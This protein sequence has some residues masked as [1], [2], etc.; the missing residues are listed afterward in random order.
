[1]NIEKD[2]MRQKGLALIFLTLLIALSVTT[3]LFMLLDS[4][5]VKNEQNKQ[6]A[7]ILSKAKTAL[8]G[9]AI[10][11]ISSGQRPGDLIRPDSLSELPANY[12]GSAEGGCLDASKANGLPLVTSDANMRCLGRLPWKDLG[13]SVSGSSE[14]D[15]TGIMPWYAVSG[16]LVD[17][18]CLTILNSNTLNLVNNPSPAPLDCSGLTLP[19]PWLTIR[20]AKGNIISNRV[21]AV[22]FLPS[23]ARGAQTR[24]SSPNLG[25]ANQYLDSV[26]V[27]SSCAVPCVPGTYNNADMDNDFIL[28]PESSHLAAENNFNDQLVYITIEDLIAAVA[29]RAAGEARSV[30]NHYNTENTHFPYAAPLGSTVNNFKSAGTNLTG[31]LPVDGTDKCSCSSG[32]SCS[33]SYNLLVNVSHNRTTGGAY[34]VATGS[35]ARSSR[36]CSCTGAGL[37]ENA[38]STISF[39]C[40]IAGNCNFVGSGDD[41]QFSYSPKASFAKIIST[42]GACSIV[43]GKAVCD[44]VGDFWLGLNV[45]LWFT[46]NIWQDFFYYQRDDAVNQL[47]VGSVTNVNAMLIATGAPILSIPQVRPSVNLNDYLDSAQNTNGDLTYESTNKPRDS[48][49]NDQTFIVSP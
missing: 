23:S 33:C 12:D 41:P 11:V 21:A 22:I 36:K 34:T 14:N 16:N 35:C 46:D 8:I 30:L 38:S 19:Y 17:P 6:S 9:Y 37:C 26:V 18:A 7:L 3:L 39:T 2:L 40:D 4:S 47:T 48:N 13:L 42:T 24:L 20:D 1:M 27:P 10:G 5:D 15:A 44:E 32:N 49:Y 29:S 45:P 28:I 43:S 25:F 31:M